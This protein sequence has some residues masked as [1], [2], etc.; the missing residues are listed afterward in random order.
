MTD[1]GRPG[2]VDPAGP[3]EQH[4]QWA[5]MFEGAESIEEAI[6]L[7]IGAASMCWENPGGAGVFDSSRAGLLSKLLYEHVQLRWSLADSRPVSAP[8][9]E[10]AAADELSREGQ[11]MRLDG[12][13]SALAV[14]RELVA[15]DGDGPADARHWR[16][17]WTTAIGHAREVVEREDQ[18]PSPATTEAESRGARRSGHPCPTFGGGCYD[19][20]H[21][22]QGGRCEDAKR[23]FAVP[24]VV[25]VPAE[26]VRTEWAAW[27]GCD[28]PNDAPV[29]YE[30][31]DDQTGLAVCNGEATARWFARHERPD[32]RVARRS[33]PAPGS[34][35]AVDPAKS[36]A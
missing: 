36:D 6:G 17:D 19:P 28:D 20:E 1:S 5:A 29:R 21:C 32:A 26:D 24:A 2:A 9:S 27:W 3:E 12:P 22:M 10:G 7:A 33:V 11:D 8:P 15:I 31:S 30:P 18:A 13:I 35:V 23:F 16:D 14:L 34:W 25:P 4:E